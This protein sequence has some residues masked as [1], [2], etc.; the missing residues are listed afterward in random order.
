MGTP[1]GVSICMVKTRK[2]ISFENY[3]LKWPSW[4]WAESLANLV[5]FS[6][7]DDASVSVGD[8]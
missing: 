6:P 1:F 2:V 3:L 5:A 8:W 4:G 7:I